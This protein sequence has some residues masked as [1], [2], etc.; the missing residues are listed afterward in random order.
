[1]DEKVKRCMILL[2]IFMMHAQ[3]IDAHP[4]L[5]LADTFMS[6]KEYYHAITECMRY[7]FLYP[8]GKEYPRSMLIMSR[9]YFLGGNYYNATDIAYDCYK[10]YTNTTYGESAL[11]NLAVMRLMEGS[12][13]F[14]YR[15]YQEYFSIYPDGKYRETARLDFI[16]A[17]ILLNNF[18]NA[19]NNVDEFMKG[20]AKKLWHVHNYCMIMKSVPK[21]IS[22]FRQPVQCLCLVL[23]IF[24]LENIQ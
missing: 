4:L 16:Y 15:T 23:V 6:N 18:R 3:Q 8:E 20:S 24:I 21:K 1:M 17:Q 2:F 13:F 5:K 12:P 19:K 7:Q 10:K 22:G 11:Y 9:A 14:A